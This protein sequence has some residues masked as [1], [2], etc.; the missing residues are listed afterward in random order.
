VDF[1][2]TPFLE[3]SVVKAYPNRLNWRCELLLTRRQD[4][5]RGKRV[6]DLASHDGRFSYACLRL[7]AAHVTGIEARPHLV[8]NA[9]QTLLAQGYGA[10]RAEFIQGDFFDV[11]PRF[12]PGRFDTILCLGVFYH[13]IRQV[14]LLGEMRRL[15]PADVVI[16][17]EIISP[18]YT[19]LVRML[20]RLGLARALPRHLRRKEYL[21]FKGE[22]HRLDQS[23]IDASDVV[24]LPTGPLVEMLLRTFGFRCEAVAWH[25][26]GIADWSHLEDYRVGKRASYFGKRT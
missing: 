18:P 22:D 8:S 16:D 11:L 10:E 25:E 6:L 24:A 2:G 17:T 14:E 23:T 20:E 7:G 26:Q 3:T 5:I 15:G 4:M 12:Q 1:A 19:R 9:T 13:T 21:F